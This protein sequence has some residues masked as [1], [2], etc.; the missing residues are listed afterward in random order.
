MNETTTLSTV[1]HL[2]LQILERN[3]GDASLY[4]SLCAAFEMS[5]RAG[6]SPEVEEALWKTLETALHQSGNTMIVVDGASHS[7]G[8]ESELLDRLHKITIKH[9]EVKCIVTGQP[10]RKSL[11]KSARQFTITPKHTHGDIEICVRKLLDASVHFQ[12]CHGDEQRAIIHQITERANGNFV[13]AELIVEL[14]HRVKSREALTDALDQSPKSIADAVQRLLST[15]DTTKSESKLLLSWCVVAARPLTLREV[16]DLLDI[17]LSGRR[18]NVDKNT[19]RY[20]QN[21]GHGLLD[22]HGGIVRFRHVSIRQHLVDSNNKR[23]AIIHLRDAHSDLV[24]RCLAYANNHVSKKTEPTSHPTH[25]KMLDDLFQAH[26]LLE[27]TTRYWTQHFRCSSMY[28]THG[29]H[30]YSSEFKTVFPSSVLFVLLEESCWGL[31]TSYAEAVE[32]HLLALAIR[33]TILT[34][35]HETVLQ[36]MITIARTYEKI[37]NFVEASSYYYFASKISREISVYSA[38]ST[39]C[40]ERYLTCTESIVVVTRTEIVTR[41][42]EM[43]KYIIE[44][45]VHHHGSSTELTI[46][47]KKMLAKLYV[48]IK[49]ISLAIALYREVHQACVEIYGELDTETVT[50]SE[51]LTVVLC[52][53]RHHE[54]ALRQLRYLFQMTTMSLEIYDSRRISIAVSIFMVLSS[55]INANKFAVTPHC[56]LREP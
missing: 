14:L 12:K 43:I 54:D 32:S 20:V 8:A 40:S 30:K 51:E 49:E 56:L 28:E 37:T 52:D 53:H 3:V 50:C 34:E 35:I 2:L 24:C 16:R 11:G 46:K 42:E 18:S 41:K 55:L 44:T 47:F 19:E 10:P 38:I 48:E 13:L 23:N 45:E 9:K 25:H 4:K 7:T 6:A 1:K 29:H 22:L 21:A 33:K 15:M 36:C 17:N 5:T 27:Y 39:F 31:Q 26:H